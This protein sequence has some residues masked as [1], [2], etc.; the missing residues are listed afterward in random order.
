MNSNI[1][2]N[3]INAAPAQEREETPVKVVIEPKAQAEEYLSDAKIMELKAKSI[4]SMLHEKAILPS[5]PGQVL[6]KTIFTLTSGENYFRNSIKEKDDKTL[7]L[8]TPF[9]F[10]TALAN[11]SLKKVN[12]V[13]RKTI[14]KVLAA[15]FPTGL[16]VKEKKALPGVNLLQVPIPMI[17][18]RRSESSHICIVAWDITT[19]VEKR[20]YLCTDIEGNSPL[21][22]SPQI[23]KFTFTV[24]DETRPLRTLAQ[25]D[26]KWSYINV[27]RADKAKKNESSVSE[28]H[29]N[30]NINSN[31]APV[32]P[33]NN[34][35]KADAIDLRSL[36]SEPA[37]KV[38]DDVRALS[39]MEQSAI[40]MVVTQLVNNLQ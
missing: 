1:N 26:E 2:N 37:K 3:N 23:T 21:V 13:V 39:F 5:F 38:F 28:L 35:R 14:R 11:V 19:I 15:M 31:P 27:L 10:T 16:F 24:A 22:Q 32:V 34:K 12:S 33:Q 7:T 40:V 20:F 8:F 18:V 4:C 17:M 9:D 29:I 36:L 6:P 25:I 30:N